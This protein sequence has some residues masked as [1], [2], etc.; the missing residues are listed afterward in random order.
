MKKF[1]DFIRDNRLNE[2][3]RIGGYQY[4]MFKRESDAKKMFI[5]TDGILGENATHISWEE[6]YDFMDKFVKN[7]NLDDN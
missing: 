7:K 2:A 5:G 4:V 3:L 1:E 6:I